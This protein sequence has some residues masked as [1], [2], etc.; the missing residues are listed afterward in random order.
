MEIYHPMQSVLRSLTSAHQEQ[1]LVDWLSE[2]KI[3]DDQSL[4][5]FKNKW[6]RDKLLEDKAEGLNWS[7]S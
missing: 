5:D 2:N 6:Q 7:G 4:K 1:I 3:S